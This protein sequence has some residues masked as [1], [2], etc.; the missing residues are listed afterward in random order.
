MAS[1]S[2]GREA[3]D[4]LTK[5]KSANLLWVRAVHCR[6]SVAEVKMVFGYSA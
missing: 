5:D 4:I 2:A 6:T 3:P 1:S